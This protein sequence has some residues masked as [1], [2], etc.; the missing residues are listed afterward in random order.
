VVSDTE[1]LSFVSATKSLAH[2]VP[3]PT[4]EG[5]DITINSPS[6]FIF[7]HPKITPYLCGKAP[8]Q[9]AVAIL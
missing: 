7:H 9:K 5:P 4:P 1:S 3:L 8:T 2:T 6:D